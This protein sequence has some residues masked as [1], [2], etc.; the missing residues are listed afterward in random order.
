VRILQPGRA[1]PDEWGRFRRQN[2]VLQASLEAA[3]RSDNWTKTPELIAEYS[4]T[5]VTDLSLKQLIDLGCLMEAAGPSAALVQV[6]PS[7]LETDAE[8]RQWPA[9]QAIANL[10]AVSMEE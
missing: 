1:P 9:G 4:D 6:E 7:M 8:G 2:Q 3:L 10:I 5:V